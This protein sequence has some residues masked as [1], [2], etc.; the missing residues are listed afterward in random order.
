LISPESSTSLAFFKENECLVIDWDPI[1]LEEDY[2]TAESNAF[3]YDD[4]ISTNKELD[5]QPLSLDKC[6]QSFR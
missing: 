6:L 3:E 1:A 4:S 2:N 5:S